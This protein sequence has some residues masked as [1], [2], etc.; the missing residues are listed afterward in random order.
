METS[1]GHS[2]SLRTQHLVGCCHFPTHWPDQTVH[3][4]QYILEEKHPQGAPATADSVLNEPETMDSLPF[5]P[6]V[7][8]R[9]IGCQIRN[10]ALRTECSAG[11][12]GP[13]GIDAAGWRRLCT[14]FH[15]AADSL[16]NAVAAVARRL[17]TTYV[18]DPAPL[19]ALIACR[20]IP[21]DKGPGVRPIGVCEIIRRII[22]KAIMHVV[23]RHVRTAVGP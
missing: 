21:L 18:D 4:E 8:D 10:A 2:A 1:V 12:Y 13:Y 15:A 19:S 6:V 3:S 17:C 14:S 20:L 11:P 9:I 23:R 16:C 5:H 7:L 22:G